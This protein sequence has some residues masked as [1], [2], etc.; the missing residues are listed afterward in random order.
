MDMRGEDQRVHKQ[1]KC[2][3]ARKGFTEGTDN[4]EVANWGA[5]A[6]QGELPEYMARR[7]YSLNS[8]GHGPVFEKLVVT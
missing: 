7:R 5:E 6:N 4:S 8:R 3:R 1:R 2:R